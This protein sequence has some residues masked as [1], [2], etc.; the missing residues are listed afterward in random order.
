MERRESERH[1][2]SWQ[3]DWQGGKKEKEKGSPFS[4]QFPPLAFFSCLLFLNSADPTISQPGRNSV[5]EGTKRPKEA[6]L[7]TLPWVTNQNK[8]FASSLTS[9][10]VSHATSE[11]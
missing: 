8:G 1:A 11:R 5:V 2:K 7:E 6:R 3:C 10:G 4:P 9:R